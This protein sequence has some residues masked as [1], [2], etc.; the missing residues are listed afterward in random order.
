MA[1]FFWSSLTVQTICLI[2]LPIFLALYT[3][4]SN[5]QSFGCSHLSSKGKSIRNIVVL[6]FEEKQEGR[7]M[8]Q[9]LFFFPSPRVSC[10][11]ET[12]K[13]TFIIER[14]ITV[15]WLKL[16]VVGGFL[17]EKNV[18]VS[19]ISLHSSLISVENVTMEE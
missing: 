15:T 8:N 9:C 16:V 10:K 11:S 3:L 19:S 13:H 7:K 12:E 5:P 18:T 4:I 2:A 6:S 14:K 1:Y 17:T